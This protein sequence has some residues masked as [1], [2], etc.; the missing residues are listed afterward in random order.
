MNKT[1]AE[2]QEKGQFWTPSWVAENMVR[3]ALMGNSNE[4]FDPSYGMGAFFVAAKKI[5]N[6]FKNKKISFWGGDIDPD[7]IKEIEKQK[8]LS[9]SDLKN[10]KVIDFIKGGITKKYGAIVANPPYL[11]HHR[12]SQEQKKELKVIAQE[13]IGKELDGRAGLHIYFL[14]LCLLSLKKNGRLSFI[15]SSDVCEGIFSNTLWNWISKNFYIEAVLTF[16]GN[17]TPFPNIDTNPIIFFIKNSPPQEKLAW[18]KCLIE[19]SE[20]IKKWVNSGF[21]TKVDKSKLI[22]ITRT[23]TEAIKTGLS[24]LQQT[25]VHKFTL[26]DFAYAMRGIATGNN[27][28]FLLSK[29]TVKK[30]KIPEAYLI[31][32]LGRTRDITSDVIDKK[33]FK[34]L[35]QKG[36][37]Y[38]LLYINKEKKEDLP[39]S[40]REYIEHGEELGVHKTPLISTRN[41]WFKMERRDPPPIFFSYLGRRNSRF[42][43]NK[44]KA[45]PLNGF[46]C[47]YPK[48]KK[49]SDLQKLLKVINHEDVRKNLFLVGK[50]Y[51]SDAVKVEPRAIEKLPISEKLAKEFGL[52]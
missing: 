42:I 22:V 3:Y 28:Y 20:E 9:K 50:S 48:S 31:P 29:D 40:L 5:S 35:D 18:G 45:L 38:H 11:R 23:L 15:V 26:G 13:H 6:E 10:L 32:A 37:P 14:I 49:A 12:I 36:R 46:L 34:D 51:G 33:T 30:F 17:S 27:E 4:L 1:R 2:L 24:R 52:I 25:E 43:F 16:S 8:L 21:S 44:A 47:I 39:K 19:D 7:L 41:P